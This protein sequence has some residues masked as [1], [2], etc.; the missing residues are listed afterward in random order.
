V[1]R[2]VQGLVALATL[3][4]IAWVAWFFWG[5]YRRSADADLAAARWRCAGHE[6]DLAAAEAGRPNPGAES[7]DVLRLAVAACR[8][9]GLSSPL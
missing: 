3:A 5:E 7:I 1:S 4:V 8:D 9:R 2:A 6:I